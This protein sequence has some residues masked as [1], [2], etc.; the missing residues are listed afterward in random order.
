MFFGN[1]TNLILPGEPENMGQGWET[2]RRRGP[3][4]DWAILKLGARGTL[5]RVEVGTRHFK[6]NY[7]DRCTVDGLDDPGAR[8]WDLVTRLDWIPVVAE[9]KLRADSQ[10]NF[11]D[12]LRRGPFT[13]LRL[14]VFPDGGVSRLRAWGVAELP[15]GAPR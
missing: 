3:G 1:M 7:P 2:K 12:L 5:R 13:H 8:P 15:P 4:H 9:S 14:C 6:G 10:A 11:E